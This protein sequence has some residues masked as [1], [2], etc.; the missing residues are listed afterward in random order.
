MACTGSCDQL[1]MLLRCAQVVV[2]PISKVAG[3]LDALKLMDCAVQQNIY[4][5]KLLMYRNVRMPQNPDQVCT[6]HLPVYL[7]S[8]V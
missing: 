7:P 8:T 6:A 4:H 3:L 5:D 2:D 1:L